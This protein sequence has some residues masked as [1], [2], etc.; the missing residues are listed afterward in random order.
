MGTLCLGQSS[1]HDWCSRRHCDAGKIIRPFV[2]RRY[3]DYGSIDSLRSMHAQIRAEVVRQESK[4]PE[5]SNNVKLG[6]GG[7]REVEFLAQVF[8][9]IRG[10]RD[11][12]LR[13][14]STRNTLLTL[15]EKGYSTPVWC[16]S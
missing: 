6:R 10:G 16:N 3:L 14:R 13:D 9:L 4:H 8:Q 12:S 15:A 1:R 5:R 7:I 2:Y 11:T